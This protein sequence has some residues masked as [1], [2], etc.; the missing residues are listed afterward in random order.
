[1]GYTAATQQFKTL[2]TY[3]SLHD[4]STKPPDNFIDQSACNM[5]VT[6]WRFAEYLKQKGAKR[7]NNALS[8]R[9]RQTKVY[10]RVSIAKPAASH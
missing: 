1:M 7:E 10:R 9:G 2:F 3:M 5:R 6:W 8:Y 4:N